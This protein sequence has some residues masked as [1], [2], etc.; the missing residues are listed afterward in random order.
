LLKLKSLRRDS[1]EQEGSCLF[2]IPGMCLSGAE[3]IQ[4][5]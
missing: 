4:R 5:Q 2:H 1:H 3:R